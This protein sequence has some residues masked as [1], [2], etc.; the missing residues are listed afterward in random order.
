MS[1]GAKPRSTSRSNGDLRPSIIE[2]LNRVEQPSIDVM[3]GE[4]GPR[5]APPVFRPAAD[6]CRRLGLLAFPPESLDR[7]PA[8]MRRSQ[9]SF[10][11]EPPPAAMAA[12]V[13]TAGAVA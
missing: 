13:A 12:R 9:T 8:E 4:G 10:G 5:G 3:E 11:L 7:L 1:R 2:D 6:A